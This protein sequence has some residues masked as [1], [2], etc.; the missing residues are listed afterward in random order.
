MNDMELLIILLLFNALEDDTLSFLKVLATKFAPVLRWNGNDVL[1]VRRYL[2][3]TISIPPCPK[4]NFFVN[5]PGK[6]C[7]NLDK[8]NPKMG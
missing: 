2:S 4:T 6:L 8:Q 1:K 7:N 5:N 3:A